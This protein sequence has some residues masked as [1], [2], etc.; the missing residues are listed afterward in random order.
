MLTVS[1]SPIRTVR[2]GSL[3]SDLSTE[4]R[5]ELDSHADTCVVSPKTSLIVNDYERPVRVHGY[6][7][8]VSERSSCRTVTAVVAYDDPVSN[9]TFMLMIHQAIEIPTLSVNLLGT[10]QLRDNDVYVNEEPK[11]MARSPTQDHHCLKIERQGDIPLVI[12]LSIKG[13]ISYFPTRKPTTQEWESSDDDHKL[14]LTAESPEWDPQTDR[15]EKSESSVVG[16]DGQVIERQIDWMGKTIVAVLNSFPESMTHQPFEGLADALIAN[17]KVVSS[18]PTAKEKRLAVSSIHTGKRGRAISARTLAKNWNIGISAAER[19]IENTAQ[20]GLR[21][22]LHPT[23]S[24]RFRTNDRQLRY[25]RLAHDVFTDTLVSKIPSWMRQN[26]YAQVF[27]TRFGWVRVFPMKNKSDAHEA[28]SLLAQRDGVPPLIVADGAKEQV[29]GTFR[30]KVKEAGSRLKQTEPYSP[31]QNA[32]EG[33]I[34]ELKRAAG[35]K[36]TRTGSPKNLWD[37]CLEL[38]GYIRSNTAHNHY[39]LNGQ[40]PETLISGQTADISPIAELGWYQWVYWWNLP[41]GFPES[42]EELGRWLGP[43]LDI[44]P[45]M[46]SKILKE[47]G[48]ILYVSTY[49]PLSED[50]EMNPDL[51]P[52]QKN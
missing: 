36:M 20:R 27:A 3:Q 30:K 24:R 10:M 5:T 48:Q 43:A 18:Y 51:T 15:F 45:A 6:D 35:R 52:K 31:W 17:V 9:E 46:T 50:E 25:R 2:L 34:R 38:E 23:L 47:N 41:S 39:E 49:R 13:V 33:E 40:V 26:K 8:K 19:T 22:V 1:L 29:M 11:H 42:K 7:D 37:H 32:A 16:Y 14:E 44:G 21:T 12:P 28:F 4:N